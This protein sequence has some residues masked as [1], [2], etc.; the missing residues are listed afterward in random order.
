M[1]DLENRLRETMDRRSP[2]PTVHPMPAN[3]AS[4]VLRRRA[5]AVATTMAFAI[6]FV[7]GAAGLFRYLS[8][9]PAEQQPAGEAT[10]AMPRSVCPSSLSTRE[11]NRTPP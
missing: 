7:V 4:R 5:A 2:S 3:T 11:Q 10:V 8:T 6:A 9:G 1:I